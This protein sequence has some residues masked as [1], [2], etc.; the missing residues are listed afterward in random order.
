MIS[1][2]LGSGISGPHEV[3]GERAGGTEY[4]YATLLV[5]DKGHV[6]YMCANRDDGDRDG[7]VLYGTERS[8]V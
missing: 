1:D 6:L 3:N 4:K 2:F 8:A 5:G 7:T